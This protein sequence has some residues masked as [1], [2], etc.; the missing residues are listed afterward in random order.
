MQRALAEASTTECDQ[1]SNPVEYSESLAPSVFSRQNYARIICGTQFGGCA[2]TRFVYFS[3]MTWP[4]EKEKSRQQK[5]SRVVYGYA[6]I[7]GAVF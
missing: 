1:G 7:H 3:N 5:K 2:R 4:L 6:S